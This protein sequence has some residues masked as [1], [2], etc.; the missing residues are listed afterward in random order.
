MIFILH[1]IKKGIFSV[2][3]RK[4]LLKRKQN[5]KKLAHSFI[6]TNSMSFALQSIV[7]RL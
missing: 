3:P 5:V 1:R 2:A 4:A 7:L 6:T